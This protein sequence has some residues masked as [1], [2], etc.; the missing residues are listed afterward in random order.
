MKE[1]GNMERKKG[2]RKKKRSQRHSNRSKRFRIFLTYFYN[3][4]AA[5]G[6]KNA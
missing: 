2:E 4:V 6:E 1:K 5:T 3:S